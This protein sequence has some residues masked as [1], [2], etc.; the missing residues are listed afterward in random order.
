M[1]A[2]A[3]KNVRILAFTLLVVMLGYG[4]I[5]PV[6]PFLIE[7]FG[8][9]GTE[10][11]WLVSTYSLMQLVCAPLWGILSDRIG[12]KPVIA[13]GVLGYAIT[14]FLFGLA[15]QFWMLFVART[16][17][18]MLSSAAMPTSMAYISDNAP[19]GERSG[20]MG[21]LGAAIGA[22]VV[23]G[24]LLGGLLSS[25][26]LS[27]PF[28]VG[29]ALAG[30]AFVLVL[31]LLPES[32]PNPE[33]AKKQPLRWQNLRQVF[34]SPAGLLLLLIFIMSFGLANFQGIIGLYAVD[35]FGF[36]TRQV[37][38]LWMV[39]GAV[40]ILGQGG[41]TGPLTK[42]FGEL[43]LIR[44]G[45]AGGAAGFLFISLAV[46]FPTL[47]L[48]LGFFTLT[49]ALIGP[50]LNAYI[51]QFAGEHQG[52]V[53]GL[54]SAATSLGRVVGPLLAGPLFDLNVE[55]PLWSGSATLLAG[56]VLA[57]TRLYGAKKPACRE[58]G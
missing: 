17:A 19:E 46:D 35:K 16:L 39:I 12:R 45:L 11:G 25:R 27:L 22:G 6:M 43:P 29:A 2:G 57:L 41:L 34:S 10:L 55:Y 20:G 31:L 50:A 26:S 47:L 53:M 51:S 54:N 23:A 28:F 38:A 42:R 37:G 15:T 40:L 18:G 48:A 33:T 58:T 32:R 30:V 56:A 1:K 21:Q 14:L 52:A 24:P 3:L 9:G 13:I 44:L 7:Q 4:M 5:M 49:L 36:T 8:A